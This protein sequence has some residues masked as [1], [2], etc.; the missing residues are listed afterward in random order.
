MTSILRAWPALL[1]ATAL[2]SCVS[3][4]ADE[5]ASAYGAFLAARYAGV[6][7]DAEGAADY[8]LQALDRLPGNE[9][10][11]DRAFITSVIAGDLDQASGLAVA[12]AEV[13]GGGHRRRAPGD[14]VER[15]VRGVPHAHLRPEQLREHRLQR[16]A[17]PA[18][19]G[20]LREHR[21]EEG[22]PEQDHVRQDHHLMAALALDQASGPMAVEGLRAR[23]AVAQS[24]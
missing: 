10:L 17:Q 12:A 16:P 24:P 1:A 2:T 8:Y 14:E 9:V 20:V 15:E 7:R 13:P 4:P 3:V 18:H 19:D 11:T 6:N 21:P 22:V 23:N 5:E